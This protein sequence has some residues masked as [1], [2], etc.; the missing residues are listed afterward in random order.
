M[1]AY[2]FIVIMFIVLIIGVVWYAIWE[3][4]VIEKFERYKRIE[5]DLEKIEKALKEFATKDPDVAEALRRVGL[6]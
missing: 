4:R 5:R 3:K 6:L 2:L 1:P